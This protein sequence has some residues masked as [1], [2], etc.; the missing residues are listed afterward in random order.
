M[1]EMC[2]MIG[3]VEAKNTDRFRPSL[4]YQQSDHFV[5]RAFWNLRNGS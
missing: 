5:R 4:N 2:R 1:A 3:T